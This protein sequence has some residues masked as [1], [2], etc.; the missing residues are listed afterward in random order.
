[1]ALGKPPAAADQPSA[2]GAKADPGDAALFVQ[3]CKSRNRHVFESLMLRNQTFAYR[4]AFAVA[5]NHAVAED[6]VQEAFL[7][8]LSCSY[9]TAKR[10]PVFRPWFY[11]V[12]VR[13]T[14][15]VLRKDTR[16]AN[17]ERRESSVRLARNESEQVPSVAEEL[18]QI[19]ARSC[20]NA[21]VET[22]ADET[23]IPLV[24]QFFKGCNQVEIGALLGMSQSQVSR[25][26]ATGLGQLRKH[27]EHY[28]ITSAACAAPANPWLISSS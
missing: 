16:R 8:V 5:G 11:C 4:V 7:R 28:G 9:E 17:R 15:N 22:M 23:R 6:G 27:L 2:S 24:L 13:A 20:L 12:V 21:V 14:K 18:A 3:Y 1:M 19:E 10:V 25:R 26:I